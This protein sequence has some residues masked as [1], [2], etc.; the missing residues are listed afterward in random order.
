MSF[1]TQ[2][3]FELLPAIYRI[4]DAEQGDPLQTLFGV[5]ADQLQVLQEDL[6]QLYDDQFIETCA[7]WVVPY[8][9]DLIGYRGL[10][11]NVPGI[12]S[13]RAEVAHTISFRRRKGTAAML[14]Q[15]ARD[16][17]G[18][19]ARVVE[20][21]Q[22][23][24]WTQ[25]MN[26]LRP[27]CLQV[28]DLRDA[29]A[30]ERLNGP[31]DSAM[32]TIDVRQLDLGGKFNIPNIGIYLWRLTA[33]PLTRSP[34]VAASNADPHCFLFHPLGLSVPLFT[35]PEHEV[36]IDHL[37]DPINV[38]DPLSRNLLDAN[39]SAYYGAG[40]SIAVDGVSSD[41]VVVCNL[42]NID[43]TNPNSAWA[44]T[45]AAGK[46]AID[47]VL[48]RLSFGTAPANPPLVTFHYGFSAMIGGGEYERLS[49]FDPNQTV[50]TTIPS[51]S[52]TI[53]AGLT[54]VQSG[55][56]AEI[57]E[58]GRYEE[59][60]KIL[61]NA[62]KT[63]EL[64]A[65]DQHRPTIWLDDD[66]VISGQARSVVVLNGLLITGHGKAKTIRVPADGSNQLM[67]L[68][69]VHCTVLSDAPAGLI[70][71]I[72]NVVVEIDNSIVSGLRVVTGSQLKITNSIVDAGATTSVALAAPDA[73]GAAKADDALPSGA[74]TLENSTV[75]GKIHTEEMTL[76]S[77]SILF[78][79][80]AVADPWSGPGG[81]G[82]P[83]RAERKQSGCVRFSYIPWSAIVPRRHRCVPAQEADRLRLQPQFTSLRYGDP[84]YAQLALS[85]PLEIRQGADDESEM[86]AFHLL[87][88]PQRESNIRERLKEYLRVGLEAG[89]FYVT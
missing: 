67:T 10:H 79:D 57:S 45:P 16:V 4:R 30:L 58:S 65:A 88:A 22:L 35:R 80:L 54:Q 14:E 68:R 86:G 21:F 76:V 15:L 31:F 82:V 33:F 51:V 26:H 78:A 84:G 12:S 37:A 85:T 52:A 47:P 38:P 48:G 7:P 69:L 81:P 83:V 87:Y 11:G 36:E 29:I 41:A 64:R 32:H 1:D 62:D 25:N 73:S 24:N 28:P 75:I 2:R 20:F 59:T 50:I 19:D 34:A 66:L 49:S 74:L 61:V 60:L 23:L 63:L 43:P 8:I 77:N 72:P 53:Q 44:H 9:G 18:W 3:L 27:S 5:I 46:V 6:A 39:L 40:K 13:P 42:A 71:D 56:V 55:G 70:V 89:F 17:T